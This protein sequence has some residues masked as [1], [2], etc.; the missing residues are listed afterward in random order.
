M[1]TILHLSPEPLQTEFLKPIEITLQH[2]IACKTPEDCKRLF[3]SKAQHH[4]FRVS[5]NQK[6]YRFDQVD[7][8]NLIPSV[9]NSKHKCHTSLFNAAT[10]QTKH[11]CYIC[12]QEFVSEEDTNNACFSLHQI[13]PR[14]RFGI[15]F[16]VCYC[17]SY[18]LDTCKRVTNCCRLLQ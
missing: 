6:I 8:G 11:C 17:L 18:L 13:V 15:N 14:H 3:F 1:S 5:N 2:F 9:C 12:I 10:L 4:N 16:E 7:D